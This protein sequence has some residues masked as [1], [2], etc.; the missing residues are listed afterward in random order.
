MSFVREQI[1][2][3]LTRSSGWSKLRK[4]HL[5][6]HPLCICCLGS[7]DLEVH[8]VVPFNDD[9]SK[10]LD[11]TNLVTL[12]DQ[13]NKS[14]HRLI[15]HFGNWQWTNPYVLEDAEYLCKRYILLKALNQKD[16]GEI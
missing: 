13:K 11:P 1:V 6:D 3:R 9:P 4:Q 16:N 2:K 7:K 10:E 12:C 15:G 5:K 8:H 14:C